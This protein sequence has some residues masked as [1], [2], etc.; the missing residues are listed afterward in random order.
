[1]SAATA[2]TI[3]PTPA[4]NPVPLDP[5]AIKWEHIDTQIA[6]EGRQIVLPNDPAPMPID[7]AIAA[8]QR[9]KKDE[10]QEY[11]VAEFIDAWPQD[12]AVA[13]SKAM[14]RIYGWSS[15]VP[16][17]GFF[18]PQPPVM[19]TVKLGPGNDEET[20]VPLGSF[21]VPGVEK[22]LTTHFYWNDNVKPPR[23]QLAVT[24]T[25]RKKDRGQIMEL[26]Q[27]AREILKTESIYKGKPI[28]LN[29]N[30]D[31]GLDMDQ[32]PTF[33]DVSAVSE[34]DLILNRE[35]RQD[36]EVSLFTPL[37]KTQLCVKNKIPLKR[38]ILLSGPYGTG[39][40]LTARVAAKVAQDNGWT[41]VMLDR[42]EG[43]KVA[44]EFA[45]RYAPCVVFAEDIDRIL[46]ER[47]DEAND[48]VNIVDGVV[49]KDHKV[50]TVLTTNHVEKIQ[51][52]ML[53]PGRLD[54]VIA[55][56]PPDAE[57]VQRLI[58]MYARNLLAHTEDLSNIGAALAGQIPATIREVV[59][60]SKLGMISRDGIRITEQD[61]LIAARGMFGHLDLLNKAD[62]KETSEERLARGLQEVLGLRA[63]DDG[64]PSNKNII[65]KMLDATGSLSR[66]IDIRTN[67]IKQEMSGAAGAINEAKEAVQAHANADKKRHSEVV[68]KLDDIA[69]NF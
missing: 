45:V 33:I 23:P 29:T 53:R 62:K 26:V 63:V 52:V 32:P 51:K 67:Q 49:T 59:E 42:V 10:E 8:L 39:K 21:K 2:K 44:L 20:Q 35:T 9:L 1:M 5:K 16:T 43:L 31:G 50:I 68:E 46:E 41:F 14:A 13:F 11:N 58:R 61:L 48:L 57:A 17:P 3:N 38:G 69:S 56:D 19:L 60:R 7:N 18:G 24:G 66:R 28:Q 47:D 37:K 40:T 12:A 15:P 22:P 25:V 27:V 54:A 65:E 34:D 30:E 55:I 4:Q 6:R 36:I 64:G